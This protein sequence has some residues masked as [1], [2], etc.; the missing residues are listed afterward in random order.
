MTKLGSEK[1]SD[2]AIDKR[3]KKFEQELKVERIHSSH[4]KRNVY[5]ITDIS[6][7]IK[8]IF[9]VTQDCWYAPI[10]V[11]LSKILIAGVLPH[12]QWLEEIHAHPRTCRTMLSQ[13]ANVLQ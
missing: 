6:L 4:F 2:L 1:N 3:S 5:H 9:I 7:D 12:C 13:F 11:L 8:K 10:R